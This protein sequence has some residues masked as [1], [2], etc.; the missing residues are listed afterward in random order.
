MWHIHLVLISI[1]MTSCNKVEAS[2]DVRHR[3]AKSG[4]YAAIVER[5]GGMSFDT[6]SPDEDK[7]DIQMSGPMSIPRVLAYS[8]VSSKKWRP[9]WS[10][11][12]IKMTFGFLT[13]IPDLSEMK[14]I[15]IFARSR[16]VGLIEKI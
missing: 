6:L 15:A 11:D 8:F 16:G 3:Y 13:L 5:R 2:L 7:S 4:L 9:K 10:G 1:F 14:F 12:P